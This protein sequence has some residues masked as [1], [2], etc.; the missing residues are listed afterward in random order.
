[1][2]ASAADARANIP[3]VNVACPPGIVLDIDEGRMAKAPVAQRIAGMG[4]LQAHQIIDAE[5]SIGHQVRHLRRREARRVLQILFI[6]LDQ[7]QHRGADR[8]HFGIV[9][10]AVAPDL[11]HIVAGLRSA[12]GIERRVR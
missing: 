11:R 1:M 4:F 12:V 2:L 9:A 10:G 8:L 7:A 6:Q 3:A 5:L